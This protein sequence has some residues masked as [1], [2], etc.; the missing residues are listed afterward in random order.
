MPFTEATARRKEKIIVRPPPL[1]PP[2]FLKSLSSSQIEEAR[3]S[4]SS[5]TVIDERI[6]PNTF[7]PP[8]PHSILPSSLLGADHSTARRRSGPITA[9][10]PHRDNSNKRSNGFSYRS[11]P[12]QQQHQQLPKMSPRREGG[13]NRSRRRSTIPLILFD[14][15][16][17]PLTSLVNIRNFATT[18]AVVLWYLLGVL[19]ISTTKVLLSTMNVKPLWLSVQQFIFGSLFLNLLLEYRLMSAVGKQ[20]LPKLRGKS[21]SVREYEYVFKYNF[22][23]FFGN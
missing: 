10:T 9:A 22:I 19:S 13:K 8:P 14:L 21:N 3:F 23:V 2:P 4:T 6:H 20:P 12:T 18:I 16:A 7:C 15:I 11:S 1:P 17:T 5:S